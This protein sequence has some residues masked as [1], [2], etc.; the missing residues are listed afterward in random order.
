M[1]TDVIT[2]HTVDNYGSAMQTY[3]TQEVLKKLGCEVE[4]IDYWRENNLPEH[5]AQQ[6]LDTSLMQK[7]KPIWGR[8]HKTETTAIK[9]MQW[10]LE[11]H[12][13]PMWKFLEDNVNLS[14]KRYTSFDE[15]KADP[16]K[17]DVYITGS[18][19]VWNSIWNDGIDRSY[20]LDFAPQDKPRIAF[21]ASIGRTEFSEDEISETKALLQ[22]Y[23]AIS[24]RE[25]SA[26]ELLK[27]IGIE[28]QLILDP[29]LMLNCNEWRKVAKGRKKTRPFLLIYQLNPNPEMDQF[30]MNLAKKKVWE[31][32]RVGF[33]RSDRQK[34]GKCIMSPSVEE[35]VGLLFQAKCVL[36]D[37]FHA[38]A[39]SLNLGTDFISVRPQKFATR[40]E[41]ILQ[42]TGQEQRL[43]DDYKDLNIVDRAIDKKH[44]KKIL[45]HERKAGME[46]LREALG[47]R[48]AV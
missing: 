18:D 17:A 6:M 8:N 48:G 5:R 27:S 9:C 39:F 31:V 19:Q 10:Y 3:A 4:I 21:S 32:I 35:F 22:K 12:V 30:A 1:K 43:L 36:T 2:L 38:T 23:T 41:S 26:V 37:S 24:V 16:P 45:D 46:W 11:H 40:I 25:E 34:P 28:S 33:G 14:K 15:L 29:T 20:F 13:S 42:L 44:V 7:L 47:I